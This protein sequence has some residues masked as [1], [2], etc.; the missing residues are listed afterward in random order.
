VINDD[1]DDSLLIRGKSK[2]IVITKQNPN[3]EWKQNVDILGNDG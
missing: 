3:C 1:V 2:T